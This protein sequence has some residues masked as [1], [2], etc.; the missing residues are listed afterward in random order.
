MHGVRLVT[1]RAERRSAPCC[2]AESR[3][4][5]SQ[6][7]GAEWQ[8]AGKISALRMRIFYF[9]PTKI[10]LTHFIS[11]IYRNIC[12]YFPPTLPLPSFYQSA[13]FLHLYYYLSRFIL[14]ACKFLYTGYL[15]NSLENS[16][17]YLLV[18]NR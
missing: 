7:Q 15:Q 12:H 11:E 9:V 14:P 5:S 1:L 3:E 4:V 17:V 8:L 18:S 2:P 16:D 13:T 6:Q 10:V